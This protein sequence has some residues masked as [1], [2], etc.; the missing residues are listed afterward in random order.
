M[1]VCVIG[2]SFRPVDDKKGGRMLRRAT[3]FAGGAYTYVRSVL[4]ES[5]ERWEKANYKTC[6]WAAGEQ[7]GVHWGEERRHTN[8]VG[9]LAE[10]LTG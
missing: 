4:N 3:I 10:P 2:D 1:G 5:D 6:W 8:Q 9:V 7:R